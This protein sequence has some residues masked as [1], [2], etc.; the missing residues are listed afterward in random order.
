ML[1][2]LLA[3]GEDFEIMWSLNHLF[4][5][6][7]LGIH[8][9]TRKSID[10]K[11]RH[12]HIRPAS[13]CVPSE[14]SLTYYANIFIE[15]MSNSPLDM[16]IASSSRRKVHRESKTV[17]MKVTG[18]KKAPKSDYP[19]KLRLNEKAILRIRI[20]VMYLDFRYHSIL[21]FLLFFIFLHV[22]LI[23]DAFRD[24]MCALLGS[25]LL[26]L[27]F[28][29]WYSLYIHTN[30]IQR[31]CIHQILASLLRLSTHKIGYKEAWCVHG[32]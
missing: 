13:K 18:L 22:Y 20:Y 16:L 7:W 10:M 21:F 5:N 30:T 2:P 12:M 24:V 29:A 8:L 26:V 31:T 25:P 9:E 1:L 17:P 6:A 23:F 14:S 11:S 4:L 19:V 3:L 27:L 32:N 15:M 28:F